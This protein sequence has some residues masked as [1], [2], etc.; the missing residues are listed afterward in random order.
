MATATRSNDEKFMLRLA[1]GM[2]EAFA[3]IAQ[4]NERSMNAEFIH[5]L[6]RSLRDDQELQDLRN[7]NR[8]L[9]TTMDEMQRAMRMAMTPQ[10]T[11]DT[12][13]AD[14]TASDIAA[15]QVLQFHGSPT[16]TIAHNAAG[17]VSW[18]VYGPE[19]CGK[20]IN[21]ARIA[22]ALGLTDIVDDWVPGMPFPSYGCLALTNHGDWADRGYW[23]QVMSFERAMREVIDY[24]RRVKV[25]GGC[26]VTEYRKG[27]TGASSDIAGFASRI[28]GN[29]PNWS[30][31][32][33]YGE[34]W[35][36]AEALRDKVLDLLNTAQHAPAAPVVQ[37]ERVKTDDIAAF[38]AAM[39][40]FHA[41]LP[42]PVSSRRAGRCAMKRSNVFKAFLAGRS[43]PPA[44]I[45]QAASDVLAE[46]RRQVEVEGWTPERDDEHGDETMANAAGCYALHAYD[47]EYLDDAPAWWPWD[48]AWWKPG[49]PRRNLIKAGALI[50]A[51]IERLDRAAQ[52]GD[53]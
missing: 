23:P 2:R 25:Q 15:L 37:A 4:D 41:M 38:E 32:V 21:A 3:C 35:G 45:A 20:S 18:I 53:Q 30:E 6:Q 52:G 31:I 36:E 50:L 5:R 17:A 34:T 43:N 8:V 9:I 44:P 48:R 24:E 28:E 42:D 26:P 40:G 29:A 39:P 13:S 33:C 16:D 49:T 19:G 1:D 11:I 47:H 10:V 12:N 51:E 14:L 46:R 7:A 27:H 22:A